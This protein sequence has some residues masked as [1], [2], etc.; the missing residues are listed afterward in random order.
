MNGYLI[1]NRS[2]FKHK[3]TIKTEQTKCLSKCLK[4]K[5]KGF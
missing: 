3:S 2:A 1:L 4:R 5:L